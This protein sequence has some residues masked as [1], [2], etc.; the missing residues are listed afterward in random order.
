M[1]KTEATQAQFGFIKTLLQQREVTPGSI[2]DERVQHARSLATQGRLTTAQASGLIE[3]LQA[4][5]RKI[6][7]ELDAGM[8]RTPSGTIYKVQRSV[9]GSGKM[10]AKELTKNEDDSWS[11][12]YR[13]LATRFVNSSHL[14]TLDEA[15][16]WGMLYGYCCICARVL[17][18]EVSQSKGIGPV[19]E[20][21]MSA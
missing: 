10:C 1:T 19:C 9:Y 15:K 8:Y 3:I 16:E 5:P 7:R 14:M 21:R 18:D 2:V 6:E 11:F 4:Q 20:G 13:G 12:E 17:T